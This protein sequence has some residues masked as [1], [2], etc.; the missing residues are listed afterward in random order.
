MKTSHLNIARLSLLLCLFLLTGCGN[1]STKTATSFDKDSQV[2]MKEKASEFSNEDYQNGEVK[3][4][5]YVKMTG[6]IVQT[7]GK[8]EQHI[9]KDD[10]FILRNNGYDYQ[11]IN[12][13]DQTF[14]LHD[15]V[16]VYGEYYGFVQGSKIELSN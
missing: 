10:R 5:T 14:K 2:L 3:L 4:K 7:D 11:V 12:S 13:S 16:N 6:E 9:K 8:D 1:V 15:K